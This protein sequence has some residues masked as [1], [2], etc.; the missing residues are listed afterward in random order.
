M[1]VMRLTDTVALVGSGDARL[2]SQYD[3]NVYAIDAPDGTVLLDTGAGETVPGLL[4]RAEEAFGAV[5][6]ALLTHAHADH[7]QGGPACRDRGIEVVAS[8]PTAD[9]LADGT[10]HDL[11]VDVARAEGVYPDDYTFENFTVDRR[12][13]AGETVIVAGWQF[14]TVQLRGHATDHVVYMID[15]TGGTN[16]FVGDAVYPDG[17]IS[18]LNIPG[19]SLADYRADINSLAGRDV[20]A[21][22]PGHGLPLLADG[23]NAI[24]QAA[25][26]L[27]GMSSPSTRT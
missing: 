1:N 19:S 21:L 10:E 12:F 18:L 20:D 25:Q 16:C 24:D 9:L 3:C 23:Q 26:A 17:S 6:H 5:S 8:E 27:S 22:F 4:E 11:G 13:T 15:G 2:S 7:S 14:E